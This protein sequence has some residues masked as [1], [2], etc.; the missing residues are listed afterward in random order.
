MN[1]SLSSFQRDVL[2]EI[3]NIGAGNATTSL[4]QLTNKRIY[5]DTPVVNVV[6]FNEMMDMVGGIEELVVAMFFRIYGDA[7]SSVY[8][9]LSIE[10]A[11]SLIYQVTNGVEIDLL[12]YSD[13]NNEFAISALKEVANIITGSYISALAD[14]INIHMQS[15]IPHLS[16]D[17]AGA[18]LTVGL[19]E[20]SQRSDHAIVINT[21]LSDSKGGENGLHGHFFLLPDMESFTAIFSALGI[22][23]YE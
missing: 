4:S 21:D 2:C 8:F 23:Q 5:M 12:E 15:S 1:V 13:E 17:M 20:V 10:E 14:F 11:E 19:L 3:G 7:P 9:I 22:E 18:V 16:I 6:S